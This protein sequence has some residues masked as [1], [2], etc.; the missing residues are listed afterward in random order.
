MISIL[1]VFSSNYE[2]GLR[3][4]YS[5]DFGKCSFFRCVFSD[6]FVGLEIDVYTGISYANNDIIEAHEET[7]EKKH[8]LLMHTDFGAVN[9]NA[10]IIQFAFKED[11]FVEK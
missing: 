4:A 5:L 2:F 10:V 7:D 6:D 1:R 11:H 9:R 8:A 3:E